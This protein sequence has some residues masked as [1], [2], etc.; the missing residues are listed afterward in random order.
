MEDKK[1]Y[2]LLIK[3]NKAIEVKLNSL[4]SSTESKEVIARIK[5]ENDEEIFND[6]YHSI[7]GDLL[8]AWGVGV[9]SD[10]FSIDVFDETEGQADI[11]ND[12]PISTYI[13][14]QINNIS[15]DEVIDLETPHYGFCEQ[16]FGTVGHI[17][18][19]LDDTFDI[20]NLTAIS[21]AFNSN[22]SI[23]DKFSY[24]G[25][26]E[27]KVGVPVDLL[28][29]NSTEDDDKDDEISIINSDFMELDIKHQL[30]ILKESD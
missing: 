29:Q 23:V 18:L 27:D 28:S 22:E 1:I 11:D 26:K 3:S 10:S 16:S 15:S 5:D 4:D 19:L 24:K 17:Q 12:S 20:N 2:L 14:S 7:S 21:T 9:S 8:E 25:Y 6:L 13:E 30:L